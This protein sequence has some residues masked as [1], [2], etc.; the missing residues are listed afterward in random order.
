MTRKISRSYWETPEL[1]EINRLPMGGAGVPFESAAAART[2]DIFKSA[3]VLPLDGEW[4]FLLLDRP[5]AEFK[6][7]RF[8]RIRVPG[9]WT[10]QGF[11]DKPVYTNVKMPFENDPP[12]VPEKNPTGIYRKR[13][14]LP[15]DW[16]SR[17]IVLHVGGAESV[18]EVFC[19]GEFAGMGKD[20]RLPSEFDLTDF[21]KAGRNELVL[22]VIRW[23]DGSYLEDQDHWWQAGVY[24]STY[25]YSTAKYGFIE[26]IFANG[27]W[28]L[29]KN[30]ALL[31]FSCR[32]GVRPE[33]DI[34]QRSNEWGDFSVELALSDLKGKALWKSLL[35]ISGSFRKDLFSASVESEI[36][37]LKPW[38]SETPNL[39]YLT[40]TLRD[41]S[42]RFV[43]TRRCRVG[44]RNIRLAYRELQIN[45]KAVLIK[46]VNRH[47]HDECNGKTLSLESML[48]DIMLLKQFNFNAVRTC[49]YPNDH[50]WYDLCDE[51]GIYVLDEANV[52]SHANYASLCRDPRW[53]NAMVERCRRMVLRDRNH[54]CIFGW[55][56]GNESGYGENHVA[57]AEA[58]RALDDSRILH[59]EGEIKPFLHQRGNVYEN[60]GFNVAN[61]FADPMYPELADVIRWAERPDDDDRPFIM[62]EYSHAMGNSNG[63]LAEYWDAIKTY[64]GL[65]G[66]FI[67]DWVDQGLKMTGKNGRVYWGYGGDCGEKDHDFDFCING[68]IWPD[69]TVH[70]A[71]YEFK[72]LAQIIEVKCV[73]NDGKVF[74][75]ANLQDFRDADWI[76]GRWEL[77]LD[78][79]VVER[80]ELPKL[81]LGPGASK[82]YEIDW[83]LEEIEL[84]DRVHLNFHFE[85]AEKTP[86]CPKGHEVASEQFELTECFPVTGA[87]L[88]EEEEN[89]ASAALPDVSLRKVRGRTVLKAA[90]GTSLSFDPVT[91]EGEIRKNA[92]LLMSVPEFNLFRACT[93]NDGIK[94]WSGQDQ[95]PMG[96]WLAAGFDKLKGTLV[97]FETE[98]L[99]GGAAAVRRQYQYLGSDAAKPVDF[100]QEIVLHADGEI[101]FS[102]EFRFD[103]Q[104]P[105]LPRV[106]V[107]A[108]AA[109]G[110]EKITYWGNGPF[111][112]YPDRCRGSFYGCYED[113]VGNMY[114]PYIMPQENGCR[115]G[116]DCMIL[117]DG[118]TDVMIDSTFA[119]FSFT[120]LHFDAEQ[121]FR[122]R[123]TCELEARPETILCLDLAQRGLG[124][125]SCGP[126]TLD[127]YT[128]EPGE[129]E[130][131]FNIKA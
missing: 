26:D 13:F 69:R 83:D 72:H 24:R 57:A 70:P 54:P 5:D 95:K 90:D 39:Y 9:N 87:G 27:D 50:R 45:G 118:R 111:E 92:K 97:M 38:S 19:N 96:Q 117:S 48:K 11:A 93:D 25:L 124:T 16:A 98:K 120:A 8:G 40:V 2:T 36:A 42:S 128:L 91:G 58:V 94:G 61:E 64:H 125:G 74:E 73:G 59:H 41:G 53:K 88:E 31:K 1:F 7:K 12:F 129:Y 107:K 15:K 127:E 86:W 65:Q 113:T 30:V 108:V 44:F 119:P 102:Q 89:E 100:Y 121:L 35:P 32:I 115:T 43:E 68:M 76:R 99:P 75:I 104:L 80:G 63:G 67:W 23:S 85:A 123:H 130:F 20:C 103:P 17:R 37:G 77:L 71:M 28:D 131:Y 52:E 126:Q 62:C 55:S 66:G 21:V 109:P 34:G 18:L 79:T 22:R 122:A 101:E 46:G 112:N 10:M 14:D 47:E 114:T 116:V 4:D 105:T 49:H 33:K 78:G 81:D 82:L 60:H 110:F 56:L 3:L 51:Y 84:G 29:E 106:G 6:G